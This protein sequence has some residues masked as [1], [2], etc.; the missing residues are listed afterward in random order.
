MSIRKRILLRTGETRWQ[1]DYRDQRGT[2]RHKQFKTKAAAVSYETKTR[3]E[4]VAGTHVADGASVTVREA[5]AAWLAGCET[6]GL[7]AQTLCGY[8]DHVRLHIEPLIGDLKLNKLTAPAAQQFIDRLSADRNRPT[9][10][11]AVTSLKA[12]VGEAVRRGLAA[13]NPLREV[14]MAGTP[15]DE[16]PVEFPT[17][18]EIMALLGRGGTLVHAGLLT[19]MRASELRGL[20]WANVDFKDAVIRVRQRADRYNKIGRPKSK[21]SRRDIPMG[22]HLLAL[23]RE[24][25]LAQPKEQRAEGLVFPDPAGNVEDHTS[26]YRRFGALQL[27]CGITQPRLGDDGKPVAGSDGKPLVTQKYGLHAMRH[28]CASLLIDQGWQAKRLQQFMGHSSI[29]LT[30]DVYGHLFKDAE[31][32]QAAMV[33]LEG[34]LLDQG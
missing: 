5:A 23:L 15:R 28:A 8:R 30:Y 29:K 16:G 1:L 26:V 13:A 33:K 10:K 4:I 27:V 19:G 7:E 2:R 11:K 17:L 9:V 6:R 34:A 31:G 18:D 12:I 21:A 24:W 22:P 14:R 25:K 32:D 3:G 20:T